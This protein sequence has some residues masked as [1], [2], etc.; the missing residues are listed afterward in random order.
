MSFI[1]RMVLASNIRERFKNFRSN[2]AEPNQLQQLQ[3]ELLA[4]STLDLS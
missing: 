1:R 2:G 3:T 4:E